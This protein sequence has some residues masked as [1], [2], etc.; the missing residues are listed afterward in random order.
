MNLRGVAIAG[1]VAAVLLVVFRTRTWPAVLAVVVG[2]T[3]LRARP[4]RVVRPA[5]AGSGEAS[6]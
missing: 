5:R 3:L 6:S 4:M 1:V 2:G